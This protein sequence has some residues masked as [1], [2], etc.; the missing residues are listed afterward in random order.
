MIMPGLIAFIK[1][2]WISLYSTAKG[3]VKL[4]QDCKDML[5]LWIN[6][7]HQCIE[8]LPIS[9]LLIHMPTQVHFTDTSSIAIGVN[10]L[11]SS[12]TWNLILPTN[13]LLFT[14]I[15]HL[16]FLIVIVQI[17]LA[18]MECSLTD[19]YILLQVNSMAVVCW[20]K[21]LPYSDI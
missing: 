8:G 12:Q 15:N 7:I 21:K 5:L 11:F 6:I 10:N 13:I 14:T 9:K 20:L 18:E 1:P 19:E 3:R 17:L 2:L 16:E 4:N